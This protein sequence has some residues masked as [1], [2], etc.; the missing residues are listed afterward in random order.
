MV[1]FTIA[2]DVSVAS[3]LDRVLRLLSVG[4][5]R[6]LTNKVDRA[7]TGLIA[8]QQCVGPL[9]TPLA[10]CAVVALSYFDS[11]GIA[12]SIGEQ[13]LKGLVSPTAMG[14][15]AVAE[16]ITNL[17][18]ARV[19]GG[20]AAAK[21]SANW[22]WA[23]KLP[24]E[25]AAIYDACVAMSNFMIA[26]G[27]AVDGGKDSLSMAA[28]SSTGP[29]AELVKAPGSL[30][31]SLYAPCPDV[32]AT[33]TPD[34]KAP[35]T[36]SS[37]VL[38]DLG[39]GR[40]RIGGSCLAQCYGAVGDVSQVPDCEDPALLVRAF[41]AVQSLLA[42][43]GAS[44]LLSYHDRS[45]G[46]LLVAALEMAFAGNVGLS[47]DIPSDVNGDVSSSSPFAVLFSEEVGMLLEVANGSL[48]DV[49]A[50]FKGVDVPA[51]VVGAP[52]AP[53]GSVTVKLAG[54]A[55]PVLSG[56]PMTSLRDTWEATSFQ[57]ER[58]QA[59]P[60]CVA[61]E[62]AGMAARRTPPYKLTFTPAPTPEAVLTSPIKPKVCVLREEGTNGDR[63]MAAVL[64]SAG[65]EV[66]DVTMSDLVA[67]RATLDASFR[68][69]IFPGG[70]SYADVM[71][72]GKGW[73]AT[74]KFNPSV[75][76]QFKAFYQ[77][78]DT[79]SLGI[80]NGCQLAALLG[81]VPFGPGGTFDGV[82][83]TDATQ[84]RFIHNASGRF[85]SRFP[86]VKIGDSPAIM[87]KGMAGSVLG[88]W[89]QHGEGQAHFPDP[90]V[91]ATVLSPSAASGVSS[92]VPLTYVDDDGQATTTYPFNPNGSPAGIAGLC[93]PDGRHLAM[94]PHPER[95]HSLWAWPWMPEEWKTSLKASP[96][97]RMFQN[98]REWCDAVPAA[99]K[100]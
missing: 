9:H 73:A 96:W 17:A 21:C 15:M 64:T 34:L 46:G 74:I 97:L 78:P 13:P 58:R 23:A 95:L 22:M 85:E 60:E 71:D 6:F 48:A 57:L 82:V 36:G 38:L 66:H 33:L 24:N 91:L 28:K 12:S 42:K 62:E 98:A 19:E 25:G 68:G 8:Q 3:A 32:S 20:L 84:P 1:P 2:P 56:V 49:L 11:V 63:E 4:S 18:A 86:A 94:M 27:V 59:N 67:G 65:F 93:T 90:A 47:L 43:P 10:D 80:C 29:D 35:S 76:S 75:L 88:V 54:L 50:H 53:S 100:A 41:D 72:S 79:F 83:V 81:W 16:A 77:R 52:G 7:V 5:K 61:Q 89:V 55:S 39:R 92:L 51:A 69:L 40:N 70:F 26:T 44:G 45:D 30:V 99:G 87:L 37:L 31:I 14:R